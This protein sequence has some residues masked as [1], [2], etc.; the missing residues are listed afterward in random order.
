MPEENNQGNTG[1]SPEPTF[2]EILQFDPF[3][4]GAQQEPQAELPTQ[5][6]PQRPA[7]YSAGT[8]KEEPP[9][10][11]PASAP[12]PKPI[13]QRLEATLMRQAAHIAQQYSRSSGQAQPQLKFNLGV[14]DQ[15][16]SALRSEDPAEFK[17]GVGAMINSVAN[18]VWNSFVQ[19]VQAELLPAIP[20]MIDQQLSSSREQENVGRDFYGKYP[21][22]NNP[23]FAPMIQ[24][25]GA[26]LAQEYATAG[27]SLAWSPELRDQIAERIF[28][29][30]PQ[31]RGTQQATPAPRRSSFSTG[32]GARPAPA[33]AGPENDMMEMIFG[34]ARH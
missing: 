12:A 26:A 14:P 5:Q 25:V 32:S 33:A 15:L 6:E 23:M 20:R 27:R 22:L 9:R 2:E 31:L 17:A 29:V 16:L 7:T 24:T 19:A 1:S 21:Q 3:D 34:P 30:L 11:Q 4:G 28:G 18:H 13:T 8:S 10:P